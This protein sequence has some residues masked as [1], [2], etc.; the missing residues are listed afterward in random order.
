MDVNHALNVVEAGRKGNKK[1]AASR[2][3]VL[4]IGHEVMERYREIKANR[5]QT[6]LQGSYSPLEEA[7]NDIAGK[8]N[9]SYQSA[10]DAY[11]EWNKLFKHEK[12]SRKP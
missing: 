7:K 3:K 2:Q 9:I 6:K 8:H 1:T 10:K 5:K 11:D 12:K 4:G